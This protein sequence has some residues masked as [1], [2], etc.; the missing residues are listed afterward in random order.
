MCVKSKFSSSP[1]TESSRYYSTD[2][3]TFSQ[4]SYIADDTAFLF[5]CFLSRY[6]TSKPQ[7]LESKSRESKYRE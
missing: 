6:P 1:I 4:N 5:I 7:N 3:Q 2:L